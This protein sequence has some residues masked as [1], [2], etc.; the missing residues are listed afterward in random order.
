MPSKNLMAIESID[1][2]HPE[3]GVAFIYNPN[4]DGTFKHPPVVRLHSACHYGEVWGSAHCE[5]GP[6]LLKAAKIVS[7]RGGIIYYLADQDGRGHGSLIKSEIYAL[8]A[9][10]HPHQPRDKQ[11]N[12]ILLDTVESCEFLGVPA[13]VRTYDHA[14]RHLQ[15]FLN[16]NE[17]PPR[18]SLL[19]N[20]PD[21]VAALNTLL[22]GYPQ[23]EVETEPL[24]IG[25]NDTNIGYLETKNNKMGHQLEL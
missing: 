19:T 16:D 14:L 3:K 25:F 6:Q 23:L 5:C 17:L 18:V 13:D 11:G 2:D 21:K 12:P 7:A 10:T 4:P 24:I 22:K 15:E 9:G 1:P 8:Q 20:N